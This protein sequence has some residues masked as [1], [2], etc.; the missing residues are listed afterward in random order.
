MVII[1]MFGS[2]IFD[3][4]VTP[5]GDELDLTGYN[6]VFEDEFNSKKLIINTSYH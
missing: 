2:V 5:R 4:P 6:F 3:S 1:E